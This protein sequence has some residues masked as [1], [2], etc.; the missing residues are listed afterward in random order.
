MRALGILVTIV[1][2]AVFVAGCTKG[3]YQSTTYKPGTTSIEHTEKVTYAGKLGSKVRVVEVRSDV[4]AD[5]RLEVY[6]ELE[7]MTGK[8]VVVQVQ[9]QFKDGMGTLMNDETNWKTIVMP[10]RSSTSYRETSMN[11]K[12]KDFIIRVKPE[13][14]D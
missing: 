14:V 6:A 11:V 3:P 8:N 7:N 12:A 1:V 9:T 10:P 2:V 4:T 5:G 13:S